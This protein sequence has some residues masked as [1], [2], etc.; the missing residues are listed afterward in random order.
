MRRGEIRRAI[1]SAL[2][3]DPAHGYEVMRRLEA[4]SGGMWRPSPGSVYP[5]LQTL[6]HEGMV[7]SFEGDGTRTFRL[8]DDGRAEAPGETDLPWNRQSEAGDQVRTLR[9]A[10]G[11]LM[12]AAKQLSGEG[13]G[14]Q[15]ERGIAVIQKR[16]R[17]C[18][19]SWRKTDR[20]D[21]GVLCP[22]SHDHLH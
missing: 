2:R 19:R 4:M 10:V 3:D 7:E 8:T 13:E 15:V 18:T 1:L 11:Q 14:A 17:S 12:G 6:E 21:L 20:N 16:A 22:Q 9:R 5:H